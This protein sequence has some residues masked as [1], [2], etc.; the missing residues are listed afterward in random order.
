MKSREM[1]GRV[2]AFFDLDGTLIARP[3][4]ERRFFAELRQG[5]AIPM[6]NYFFWLA[7]AMWLAPRGIGMVLYA[8]K[9]YLRRVC[10]G[11]D[12]SR[13]E[14]GQPEM[15]VPR[16]LPEGVN[17]VAWHAR[18]GHAIVLVSG[19]LAPLAQEMALALVARLAVRG[20]AACVAVCAT[21]LEERDG[22][23]TGRIVGDAMFGEAKARAVRKIAPEKGFELAQC[24]AYGDSADDRWIL[25][26]VGRPVA[27]NPSRRLER[28]ACRRSWAVLTW[29]KGKKPK[30]SSS[31]TQGDQGNAEE[32]WEHVG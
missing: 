1:A 12:R 23:W 8:N 13:G 28:L 2:A 7:R 27:V 21:R 32:T 30:Q 14:R 10:A 11:G 26:T 6:R 24:Y 17:Q 22:R 16:F 31:S 20:I 9:M 19:T 4:L 29:A 18:Q 5:R 3:S 15:A 25:E